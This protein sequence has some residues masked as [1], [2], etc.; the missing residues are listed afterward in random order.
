MRARLLTVL[1][2]VSGLLL[3]SDFAPARDWGACGA[4]IKNFCKGV[5]AGQGRIVRCLWQHRAQLSDRCKAQAQSD[6]E[7]AMQISADCAADAKKFCRGIIPG[8]GR[9]A[10]CLLSHEAELTPACRTHAVKVKA[11]GEKI[12][13]GLDKLILGACKADKDKF[14]SGVKPGQNR[15][16]D[17]LASHRAALKPACKRKLAR[18]QARR[19]R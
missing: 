10:A 13:E 18:I 4:D 8:K 3:I 11:A 1:T 2:V 15:I 12:E 17:C 7:K 6:W 16:I 14:C 19:H 5:K 9:I